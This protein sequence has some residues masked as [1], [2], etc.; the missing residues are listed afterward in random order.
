MP[1]AQ[2]EKVQIP[3]RPDLRQSLCHTLL[4]VGF[5]L[6]GTLNP[7]VVGTTEASFHS[8]MMV[9]LGVAVILSWYVFARR[10]MRWT[11]V[12]KEIRAVAVR[13]VVEIRQ[14]AVSHLMMS[15]LALLLT[16]FSF[17]GLIAVPGD[18]PA[19]A[20]DKL[21]MGA[22]GIA[23]VAAV[24]ILTRTLRDLIALKRMRDKGV[25]K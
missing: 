14:R 8:W 3:P 24:A 15:L 12:P 23:A 25:P 9:A 11:T 20:L 17:L 13:P 5:I 22:G 16:G 21:M 1:G 4:A 18:D 19:G 6:L 7:F 10:W 2:P